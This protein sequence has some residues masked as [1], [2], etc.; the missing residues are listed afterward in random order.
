MSHTSSAS[1]IHRPTAL[2]VTPPY[3]SLVSSVPEESAPEVREA[4]GAD[5][6]SLGAVNIEVD[7][8]SPRLGDDAGGLL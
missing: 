4:S 8:A 3:L 1:I 2:L 7:G 6:E 5:G